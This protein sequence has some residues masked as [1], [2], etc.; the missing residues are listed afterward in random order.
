MYHFTPPTTTY[1]A[2]SDTLWGRIRNDRGRAVVIYDDGRIVTV[3]LPPS[4][5]DDG[6][7]A[8]YPG[9][10]T[11]TLTD[12]EAAPLLEAGYTPYLEVVA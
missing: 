4:A 7:S 5:G 6:V 12:A 8:V 10:R 11:Y 1:R 2:G 9:G 3:D